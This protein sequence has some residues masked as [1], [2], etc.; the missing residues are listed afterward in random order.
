MI[1]LLLAM[2]AVDAE[3]AFIADAK[4]L[5][6][7]TAF[8][9]WA[10]PDAIF[11]PPESV[12][13]ALK[14]APDPPKAVDW[15]PTSS[16]VSCDGDTAANTGGAAWPDG[17]ASYFSTIWQRQAD[18]GWKYKLDHGDNLATVRPR[19]APKVRK[20]S[21]TPVR[22]LPEPPAGTD[23]NG[24]GGSSRDST[25]VWWH[26]GIPGGGHR[27]VVKLWNGRGWDAVIEDRV[28][29]KPKAPA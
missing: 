29:P 21:C 19:I 12:H 10:A 11:L 17:H 22:G 28:V 20:A 16:F 26:D 9:K 7:W 2:T 23:G 5:G 24:G 6:Q 14:D 4:T 8:R 13:K 25:L 15:W 18:G 3:R 27:F 1:V